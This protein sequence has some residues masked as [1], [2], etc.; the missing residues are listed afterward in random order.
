MGNVESNYS[1][2]GSWKSNMPLISGSIA[3]DFPEDLAILISK[4][5]EIRGILQYSKLSIINRGQ[6]I[7]II[8]EVELIPENGNY[9]L[10]VKYNGEEDHT[11]T[12][13]CNLDSDINNIDQIKGIYKSVNPT[14]EGS[15]D[16]RKKNKN[17]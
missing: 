6:V 11:I 4:K 10:S 8:I 5:T 9:V 14:D 12:Y 17:N 15:F 2:S 1:W 3:I 13:L 16:I 7:S